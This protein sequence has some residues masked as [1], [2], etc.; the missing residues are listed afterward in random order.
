VGTADFPNQTGHRAPA[1]VERAASS[2]TGMT[3]QGRA[4]QATQ[5]SQ[6]GR[7]AV[8][9][10]AGRLELAAV[11]WGLPALFNRAM[12]VMVPPVASVLFRASQVRL[13]ITAVAVAVLVPLAALVE[14]AGLAVAVLAGVKVQPGAPM[15]RTVKVAVPVGKV[16]LA[17]AA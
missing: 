5:D 9:P 8:R 7:A 2:W 3:S 17:V 12:F 14:R 13:F 10:L 1:A 15:G 11:V 6:E 16:P 4:G